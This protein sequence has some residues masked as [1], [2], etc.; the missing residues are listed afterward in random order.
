MALSIFISLKSVFYLIPLGGLFLCDGVFSDNRKDVI[1]NIV[2]FI[3]FFGIGAIA[4]FVFHA[5]S[6]AVPGVTD[7]GESGIYTIEAGG[8]IWIDRVLYRPGDKVRLDA[9]TYTISSRSTP[10]DV[11]LRWGEDLYRPPDPPPNQ[12]VLFGYYF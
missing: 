2:F 12:P 9:A 3:I 5:H 6:L 7:K 11:S 10:M 4:L 1:R 8:S